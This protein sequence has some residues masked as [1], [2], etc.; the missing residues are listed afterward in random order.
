[1]VYLL[2]VKCW[3]NSNT[4]RKIILRANRFRLSFL[5]EELWTHKI[6]LVLPVV[7]VLRSETQCQRFLF[8]TLFWSFN[9]FSGNSSYR[10]L[11]GLL[12]LLK[13]ESAAFI[14]IVEVSQS[15]SHDSWNTFLSSVEAVDFHFICTVAML[16]FQNF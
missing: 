7:I 11:P 13:W 5:I 16:I 14:Y 12:V 3:P 9:T 2:L 4:R 6:L 1:M 15:N 8:C 10:L